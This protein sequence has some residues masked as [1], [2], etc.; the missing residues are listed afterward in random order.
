MQPEQTR[1]ADRAGL[2]LVAV[3]AVS[4]GTLGIF[5]KL[6]S[7]HGISLPTLLG[8]RFG[9][10]AVALWALALLRGDV[11]RLG[12]RASLG[13]VAMG[14][15]YVLQAAAYFSS[16]RTIPAAITSILLYVYPVMVT[17]L[18]R[19]V[20]AE[21]LTRMRLLSLALA[22]AGVVMVVGPAPSGHLDLGGVLLGLASAVVYS[23]Y[24]LTGGVLLRGVPA[25][26]ASAVI[27]TV[28]GA[29]FLLFGAATSQLH[30][31]DGAGWGIVA[32]TAV[33]PTLIAATM[34]L[35][36]LVRVGPTRASIVSTL[37]PATTV[38]LAAL[39]LGEDLSALRLVG[40]A[41]VLVAAVLVSLTGAPRI[42]AEA[43]AVAPV[44]E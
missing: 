44:R 38:V 16:L 41:V 18:A 40:G 7:R 36:G 26:Y 15:L 17:L 25:L 4:F 6:A 20:V 29:S 34:F 39:V 24:I 3:S 43:E 35:G 27:T 5:G 13:V 31:L 11:R 14:G 12:T 37:E 22:C 9:M 10:A 21:P 2:A 8:L 30:G 1:R 42:V 33:V 32:G 28:G 23:T 19:L